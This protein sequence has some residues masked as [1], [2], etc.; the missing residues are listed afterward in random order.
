[1]RDDGQRGVVS[2]E[3]IKLGQFVGEFEANLLTKAESDLAERE[4]ESEK[5]PVYTLKVR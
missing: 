3:D 4:Y 2:T 1:M 5:L